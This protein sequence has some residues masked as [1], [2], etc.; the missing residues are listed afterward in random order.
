MADNTM[1]AE[2]EEEE[3]LYNQYA[4]TCSGHG[5]ESGESD[6]LKV[7]PPGVPIHFMRYGIAKKDFTD[8]FVY[9]ES[10][11][12]EWQ[13]VDGAP[14]FTYYK[15]VRTNLG[16]GWL[17]VYNERT[18]KIEQYETDS[19]LVNPYVLQK[20]DTIWVAYSE[21]NWCQEYADGMCGDADK[22]AKRMQKIS[23]DE[24]YNQQ[25]CKDGTD[26]EQVNGI[27]FTNHEA[28]NFGRRHQ[29]ACANEEEPDKKE[30]LFFCLHDPVGIAYQLAYELQHQWNLMDALLISI[31]LGVPQEKVMESLQSGESPECLQTEEQEPEQIAA[32]FHIA[33]TL[34]G[35][36]FSSE[37]A[38]EK[39]GE[40]LDAERLAAVLATEE[41]HRQ[42]E[43]IQQARTHLQQYLDQPYYLNVLSDNKENGDEV[44]L[45]C[46]F[47]TAKDFLGLLAPMPN[48]KDGFMDTPEE[49][50][51]WNPET[52]ECQRFIFDV[53]ELKNEL[54]ELYG[55]KPMLLLLENQSHYLK[56]VG[57]KDKVMELTGH[58]PASSERILRILENILNRVRVK[59]GDATLDK[60]V[61]LESLSL[62]FR[63]HEE[64]TEETRL[65]LGINARS[66]AAF[67]EANLNRLIRGDEWAQVK[68][69]SFTRRFEEVVLKNE[70]LQQ[71]S[72][73]QK[74]AIWAKFIRNVNVLNLVVAGAAMRKSGTLFEV[75]LN[76]AKIVVAAGEVNI[77]QR[78]IKEMSMKA[79]GVE[80]KIIEE[81]SELTGRRMVR[82][83][84][85]G[86]II[87]GTEAI[88]NFW[89]RDYD[90]AAAYGTAAVLGG[91]SVYAVAAGLAGTAAANFWNPIGAVAAIGALTFGVIAVF[92]ED[93]PTEQYAK[94]CIFRKVST[95]K[96]VGYGIM[97]RNSSGIFSGSYLN[98]I[99]QHVERREFLGDGEWSDYSKGFKALLD[100]LFA[101]RVILKRGQTKAVSRTMGGGKYSATVD[102]TYQVGSV[103]AEII[104]GSGIQDVGQ[105]EHHV[106]YCPEGAG[107][108]RPVAICN[109][110]LRLA[111]EENEPPKVVFSF[112]IPAVEENVH[113]DAEVI[114]MCRLK[115]NNGYY[116]PTEDEGEERYI[117]SRLSVLLTDSSSIYYK[118][119]RQEGFVPVKVDTMA[120]ILNGNDSWW[121]F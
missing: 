73:F 99:K 95:K 62:K 32:L 67:N 104:Y 30:N 65:M 16:E 46:R 111:C 22:R 90:A 41:R 78:G 61:E 109:Y 21:V 69:L 26:V 45:D 100:V 7:I 77:A 28:Y 60:L 49:R 97:L 98:Q 103:H 110:S 54:G 87:D 59:V 58:L 40:N 114:V 20:D 108:R 75:G 18:G 64:L 43:Q 96:Y 118:S 83:G 94:H 36:A 80:K 52:D 81:F 93:G 6:L 88:Y 29:S 84:Y 42:Q 5:A 66:V 3:Q 15:Y 102:T 82:V 9:P 76:L 14:D 12:P 107:S 31:K 2:T 35:V 85:A 55:L 63:L 115:T 119:E 24:W 19:I 121:P 113:P 68:Q 116:L 38:K 120:N 89:Q 106:F 48:S 1:A 50:L 101:G 105:L 44:I 4:F 47:F 25:Q 39:M 79:I 92:L 91:L 117:A 70:R 57:I 71:I 37:D 112:K 27:F 33:S 74:G 51:R 86:A 8:F 13:N 34:R 56:L 10:R 11:E 17:Y 53:L 72:G 23:W